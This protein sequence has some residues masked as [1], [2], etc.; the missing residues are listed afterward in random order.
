MTKNLLLLGATGFAGRHFAELA[1]QSGYAVIG[2][3]RRPGAA[4]ITCEIAEPGSVA[5]AVRE[6]APVAVVNLAGASS[7]SASWREPREAFDV[8]A[9]GTVHLL[10]ALEREAP[11]A[12][13]LCV[14]SGEVYGAAP[15]DRLPLTEG[16]PIQ[17]LSPYG[18]SKAALEIACDQRSGDA[19][20]RIAI[21]RAFNHLGPGQSD[22]FV[23]SSFARQVAEAERDGLDEVSLATGNL[24][25]ARDF[26][27]VRDMVRAYLL[28]LEEG[29]E[30]TFNA[31]SER[32]TQVRE[33]IDHLQ[34]A[35]ALPI[36]T[37]VDPSRLRPAEAEVLYGS[38]AR[39]REA[40]GW[41]PQIPLERT[42]ADLL[43][44]WRERLTAT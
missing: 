1:A 42:L 22:A 15:E 33:L 17:P 18:L 12:H 11:Q 35:T 10:E 32:A 7:V 36:R 41:S 21:V 2:A 23:A 39:L 19:G 38:A 6:A 29:L 25:P 37:E 30:G 9:V 16:A 4:E 28:V 5:A 14:S 26:T 8:N 13:L 3:S 27:D 34:A 20:P 40:T 24:S 43:G 31:C 44:W